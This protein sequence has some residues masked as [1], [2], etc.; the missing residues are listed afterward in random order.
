M[1]IS[2]HFRDCKAL[3]VVSLTR[4]RGATASA[5][6]LSFNGSCS[7]MLLLCLVVVRDEMSVVTVTLVAGRRVDDT[8]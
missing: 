6:P 3:L 8:R 2:W 1:P 7:L 4:V 5:G